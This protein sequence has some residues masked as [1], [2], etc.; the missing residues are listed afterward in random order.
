MCLLSEHRCHFL[1]SSET[2]SDAFAWNLFRGVWLSK[3]T[4]VCMDNVSVYKYTQESLKSANPDKPT[5]LAQSHVIHPNIA[6]FVG[7]CMSGALACV[8]YTMEECDTLERPDPTAP[9]F[10]ADTAS[11]DDDGLP[12]PVNVHKRWIRFLGGVLMNALLT[13]GSVSQHTALTRCM[14]VDLHGE[15]FLVPEFA[16]APFQLKWTPAFGRLGTPLWCDLVLSL[17]DVNNL[18]ERGS[19]GFWDPRCNPSWRVRLLSDVANAPKCA[20]PIR[21]VSTA[22]VSLG[23]DRFFSDPEL[24]AEEMH[25]SAWCRVAGRLIPSMRNN[26]LTAEPLICAF[27]VSQVAGSEPGVVRAVRMNNLPFQ[28]VNPTNKQRA[29]FK[30]FYA[31]HYDKTVP[32]PSL[33]FSVP[34]DLAL[35]FLNDCPLCRKCEGLAFESGVAAM[36]YMELCFAVKRHALRVINEYYFLSCAAT[37]QTREDRILASYGTLW[38]LDTDNPKRDWMSDAAFCTLNNDLNAAQGPMDFFDSFHTEWAREFVVHHSMHDATFKCTFSAI[39]GNAPRTALSPSIDENFNAVEHALLA[40]PPCIAKLLSRAMPKV[41][42]GSGEHPTWQMRTMILNFLCS[43]WQGPNESPRTPGTEEVSD[44]VY[45]TARMKVWHEFWR[46]DSTQAEHNSSFEAFSSSCRGKDLSGYMANKIRVGYKSPSCETCA[47]DGL[48]PFSTATGKNGFLD[49]C[50][51][52][53]DPVRP[54]VGAAEVETAYAQVFQGADM[55]DMCSTERISTNKRMCTAFLKLKLGRD[56]RINGPITGLVSYYNSFMRHMMKTN[57]NT[58]NK[59][60]GGNDNSDPQTTK[61]QTS[62][63]TAT[64]TTNEN[65]KNYYSLQ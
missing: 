65:D 39:S 7:E 28:T 31:E 57:D 12:V 55:E 56:A 18:G 52:F 51:S 58:N 33:L 10:N 11:F 5:R 64:T 4:G 59:D 20:N 37:V 25:A 43:I 13:F 41:K 44:K 60:S 24:A 23:V 22:I 30:R 34:G 61:D 16:S 49:V 36:S 17:A 46:H 27:K 26:V 1:P 48:C 6:K 53:R 9:D 38:T 47:K 40:F 8:V 2:D 50:R 54:N 42:G 62:T 19:P 15:E 3:C 29:F 63:T 14:L 32:A 45:S 21:S 35:D